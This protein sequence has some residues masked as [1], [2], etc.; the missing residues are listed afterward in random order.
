[1]KHPWRAALAA[2]LAA[3]AGFAIGA[4]PA[5]ADVTPQADALPPLAIEGP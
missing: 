4:V 3:L 1:M 5:G 2:T